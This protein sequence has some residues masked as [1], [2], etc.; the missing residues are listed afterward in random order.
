[1][2]KYLDM[3]DVH[4]IISAGLRGEN[5]AKVAAKYPYGYSTIQR[6]MTGGPSTAKKYYP[7]MKFIEKN[8]EFEDFKKEFWRDFPQPE[9]W[10]EYIIKNIIK[11]S[12]IENLYEIYKNYE[13]N[14]SFPTFR[15]LFINGEMKK[16]FKKILEKEAQE[17]I[18]PEKIAPEKIA[19]EKIQIKE[20]Q[21][22]TPISADIVEIEKNDLEKLIENLKRITGAKEIKLIF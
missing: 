5:I 20:T 7:Y 17:K 2:P 22:K 4:E 10:P 11:K 6:L 18:A 8:P 19:P 9:F 14:F 12:A 16:A 1:M 3:K 21:E 13:F 15:Q